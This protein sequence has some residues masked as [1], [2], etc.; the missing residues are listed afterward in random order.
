MQKFKMDNLKINTNFHFNEVNNMNKTTKY[1]LIQPSRASIPKP[2]LTPQ[3]NYLNHKQITFSTLIPDNNNP[4]PQSR[5]YKDNRS[6]S[7]G[8]RITK[9][10]VTKLD[11]SP[12]KK[13]LIK[14]EEEKDKPIDLI[15]KKYQDHQPKKK[16]VLND[17]DTSNVD[18]NSISTTNNTVLPHFNNNNLSPKYRKSSQTPQ[19]NKFPKYFGNN[20]NSNTTKT[21][22]M[23]TKNSFAP[24][25]QVDFNMTT[26]TPKANEFLNI[27]S[28]LNNQNI[29]ISIENLSLSFPQYEPSKHS[30]KSLTTIKAYSANTYQGIIR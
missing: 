10:F 18:D 25:L 7:K 1:P 9:S 24:H 13:Y 30:Q 29:P 14:K 23:S 26:K 22:P 2:L 16:P 5:N 27:M 11:K 19:N 3:N 8:A 4:K 15:L 28:L 6:L 12:N 17:I 21:E 20:T